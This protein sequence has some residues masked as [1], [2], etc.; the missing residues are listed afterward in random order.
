MEVEVLTFNDPLNL[1]VPGQQVGDG[2]ASGKG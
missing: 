1:G 2:V